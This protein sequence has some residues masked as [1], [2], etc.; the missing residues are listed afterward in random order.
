MSE[1]LKN[2]L[3]NTVAAAE[4]RGDASNLKGTDYHLLYAIWLL[5]TNQVESVFFFKGNDLLA[6]PIPPPV[7]DEDTG[8]PI[9]AARASSDTGDIWI[10]LKCTQDAWTCS[11]L[12]DD[13]L[14]ENFVYNS[15]TSESQGNAWSVRL[16]TNAEVRCKEILQFVARPSN[17]PK[18]NET[19]Q[20]INGRIV[21]KLQQTCCDAAPTPDEVG[22]RAADI[23]RRLAESEA[24][25]RQT[26]DA[27]IVRELAFCLCE[28]RLVYEAHD[29]LIGALLQ[30][31]GK[32]PAKAHA[33]DRKWLETLVGT[34]LW[35]DLPLDVSANDG[36]DAQVLSRLPAD[37]AVGQCAPRH[38]MLRL[39]EEFLCSSSPVFV[40]SGRSGAGKSWGLAHWVHVSSGGR[41]RLLIP[42]HLL[43]RSSSLMH[44]IAEE[45]RP[46]TAQ[47]QDDHLI[48]EKLLR[49]SR[50]RDCGPLVVV[51][52]DLKPPC[53]HPAEFAAYLASIVDEARRFKVKMIFSCQT[54]VLRNLQPFARISRA[55][56]HSG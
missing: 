42:G 24:V 40:L 20:A 23:L 17:Y 48:A 41:L 30:D 7:F 56:A 45:L 47:V 52:D 2:E 14:I 35:S 29:R 11:R 51:I 55:S 28:R 3:W 12:L 31:A 32:G 27:E 25:S 50:V 10:Q 37:F 16:V 4:A 19:L 53:E 18:L 15:F 8:I 5:V 33:Y 36:C 21:S 39:C 49:P 9:S 6:Q 26:I 46:L 38:A 54:D 1:S 13:N 22:A 43:T 44:L 34:D